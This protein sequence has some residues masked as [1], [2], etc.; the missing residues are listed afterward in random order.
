M[1]AIACTKDVE[2]TVVNAAATN[3]TVTVTATSLALSVYAKIIRAGVAF[4]EFKIVHGTNRSFPILAGDSVTLTAC[5]NTN[6]TVTT[7]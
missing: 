7:A 3:L 1:A 4:N 2:I 5:G 6:V